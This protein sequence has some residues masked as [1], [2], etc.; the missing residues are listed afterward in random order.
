MLLHLGLLCI[1]L[2][3][4]SA[5]PM[6]EEWRYVVPAADPLFAHPPPRVVALSERRP[7]D[8]SEE[9]AYR[10]SRRRYAQLVYGLGRKA[11]AALVLDEIAPGDMDLYVD[12]DRDGVITKHDLVP[13]KQL[14][15]RPA[16]TVV[17]PGATAKPSPC[18]VFIRYGKTSRTLAVATCGY[19]E[20]HVTLAGKRVAARRVDG[21]ANGLLADAM[22]RLWIDRNGD[23]HFDSADE[24]FLYAPIIRVGAER[25]AVRGDPCGKWLSVEKLR[26][27]GRIRIRLPSTLEPAQVEEIQ[28][29]VQS[30]DGIVASLRDAAAEVVVPASSYRISSLLLT[31][32]DAAGAAAWGYVFTDHGDKDARWHTVEPDSVL[33]LDPVGHITFSAISSFRNHPAR[34]GPLQVS[35]RLHTGD[36]LLIERA[37][38]AGRHNDAYDSGCHARIA[39]LGERG[40]TVEWAKSGFA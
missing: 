34:S 2:G 29:T 1:A 30:R 32:K 11:T 35:P 7:L 15:W 22:D 21:D 6:Q 14:T 31:L 3:E 28:L 9:V 24:E 39:L 18:C 23:G 17:G 40:D 36:G 12:A 10:G 13:G 5:A 27:T 16:L 38:R 19:W 4:D 20:G 26:G 25:Y 8:L 37:Y 33:S